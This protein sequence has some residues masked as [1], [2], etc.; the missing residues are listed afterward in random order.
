MWLDLGSMAL[1]AADDERPLR[2][3]AEDAV[4]RR[5]CFRSEAMALC[6]LR[7]PASPMAKES[8]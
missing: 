3:E 1:A 5:P 2:C 7:P 8:D 4:R 6:A